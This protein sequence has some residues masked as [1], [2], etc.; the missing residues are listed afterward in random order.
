MDIELFLG[1]LNPPHNG[2]LK[3]IESM[4]NPVVVIVKGAKTSLD[5]ERN[6]L[7]EDYQVSLIKKIAPGVGVSVSPN[8]FLPGIIGYFRKQG[9]EVKKVYCGA[10]RIDGYKKAIETA[11]KKMDGDQF[12]VEFVETER[13]TSASKVREAIRSDNYEEFKKLCPK[14]MWD[15]WDKLRGYLSEQDFIPFSVFLEEI[16]G[17]NNIAII[18]KQMALIKRKKYVTES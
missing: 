11:N 1:R 8:G 17:T 7:P 12:D 5:K 6:P 13:V 16:T 18:P 14:K 15:E 4:K 3:I 9:K 10:D 2:H